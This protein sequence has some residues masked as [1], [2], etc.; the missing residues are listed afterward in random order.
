MVTCRHPVPSSSYIVKLHDAI[1][2]RPVG[3]FFSD[4]R[5]FFGDMERPAAEDILR[6]SSNGT[7]LV[8]RNP[9]DRTD[10]T[11]SLKGATGIIHLKLK[12]VNGMYALGSGSAGN[13]SASIPEL[14]EHHKHTEI[15]VTGKE[16]ILLRWCAEK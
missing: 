4:T 2:I 12:A 13:E 14:I 8:R 11:M 16:N 9:V 6:H 5:W 7:F 10:L 1:L 15:K 3:L